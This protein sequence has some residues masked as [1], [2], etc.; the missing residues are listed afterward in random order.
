MFIHPSH[1]RHQKGSILVL[2]AVLA[3]LGTLG[4][5]AWASLI[6]AR[7]HQV[8]ASYDALKRRAT[9]QSSKELARD[10]FYTNHLHP[11][12]GVPADV[13][14]TIPG[15]QTFSEANTVY[16]V[17]PVA[18]A[19]IR[20]FAPVP[21]TNATATRTTKSGVGPLHS[22]TTDVVVE[23]S[24]NE[25]TYP[26]AFQLRANHPVL[27]GE[28]LSVYP[29]V[30]P[31]TGTPLVLGNLRV[32]G[33]AVFWDAAY[34]DFQ[35]GVRADEFI[36]PN[37]TVEATTY[38]QDTAGNAVLPSNYPI[39]VQT[40]GFAGGA[41]AYLGEL[42]I[43]HSTSNQHNTYDALIRS[44]GTFRPIAGSAPAAI[45]SGLDSINTNV[46]LRDQEL[47]QKIDYAV[48]GNPQ[49]AGV[50]T[51]IQNYSPS[52]SSVVLIHAINNPTAFATG[53]LF[54]VL[55]ANVPLANDTLTAIAASAVTALTLAE[56]LDLFEKSG[57]WVWSDGDG[58]VTV[59]LYLASVQHLLL[60]DVSKLTLAGPADAADAATL[61]SQPPLAFTVNNTGSTLL[62]RVDFVEQSRRRFVLAI[63][64]ETPPVA[65]GN[66]MTL[67]NFSAAAPF[68][69][70]HTI[71]DLQNTSASFDTSSINTATLVGGIRTNHK[72]EV[73]AGDLVLE[74]QFDTAGLEALMPRNA[75][76]ETYAA[77]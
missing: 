69:S 22:F 66:Y 68:R 51:S 2:C 53:E 34:K 59:N 72:L 58:A 28:L 46:G 23:V 48:A 77:P 1:R 38:L 74:Q 17:E 55:D 37:D 43:V 60:S 10:A 57:V 3:A 45:G 65:P 76:V 26:V 39:P 15:N 70:W 18:S 12:S 42:D 30:E 62:E 4:V 64:H 50:A 49:G 67:M 27:G 7:G 71:L 13:T 25:T 40:T 61:A 47:I 24:D 29:P 11:N 9:L 31:T 16:I 32:N 21:L 75:W 5:L 19:T 44:T 52:M 33:R 73:A 6:D 36:L 20:N 54:A 63:S 41:P 56:K 35:G 14:Y 8:E